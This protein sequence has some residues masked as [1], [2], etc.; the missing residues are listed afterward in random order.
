MVSFK[1]SVTSLIF[2][3]TPAGMAQAT[4][5]QVEA[6]QGY[7][8]SLGEENYMI[9][10]KNDARFYLVEGSRIVANFPALLGSQIG[11]DLPVESAGTAAS[12][13]SSLLPMTDT[14]AY[15]AFYRATVI[16]FDCNDTFTECDSIHGLWTHSPAQRR[17]QRLASASP[18]DNR[19]SNGCVNL[20]N[21][22]FDRVYNFVNTHTS[23][24][25]GRPYFIV[26]PESTDVAVTVNYLQ[27]LR[28]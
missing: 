3:F 14:K 22:D 20:S 6:T 9:L 5:A 19:I 17:P 28:L 18:A 1:K 16:H 21:P 8:D 25:G 13:F 12:V 24:K 27:S 10:D 2:A 26:M 7:M 23:S 11:D 15:K 4:P